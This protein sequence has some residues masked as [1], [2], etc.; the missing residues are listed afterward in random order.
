MTKRR[1]FG[2]LVICSLVTLAAAP[3]PLARWSA[4]KANQ[5][6]ATQPWLVGSNYVLVVS[7]T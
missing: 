5:W 3:A 6:Y 7:G 4:A 2:L 1:L